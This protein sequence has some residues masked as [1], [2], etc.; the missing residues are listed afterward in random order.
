MRLVS[1]EPWKV[2]VILVLNRKRLILEGM[3][4]RTEN[5]VKR[6]WYMKVQRLIVDNIYK[7][8]REHDGQ[9]CSK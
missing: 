1:K 4:Y 7:E 3:T 2:T 6:H 9:V 8:E 5:D